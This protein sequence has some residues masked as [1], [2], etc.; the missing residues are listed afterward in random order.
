MTNVSRTYVHTSHTKEY[1]LS[2]YIRMY[3][4]V[5][6][7]IVKGLL[8]IFSFMLIQPKERKNKPQILKIFTRFLTNYVARGNFGEFN[9]CELRRFWVFARWRNTCTMGS[10]IFR[11]QIEILP[12]IFQLFLYKNKEVILTWVTDIYVILNPIS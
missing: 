2:K 4:N 5:P 6:L 7:N 11:S 3:W 1:L 9:A 10:E 8:N 12:I